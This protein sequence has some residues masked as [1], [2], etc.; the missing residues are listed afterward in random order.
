[1]F[2]TTLISALLIKEELL[3]TISISLI[4]EIIKN[5]FKIFICLSK[6]QMQKLREE[7][8]IFTFLI[9]QNNYKIKKN[10]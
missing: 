6:S 3:D 8:Y 9:H 2:K 5:N 1:M 4:E 7:H 10:I